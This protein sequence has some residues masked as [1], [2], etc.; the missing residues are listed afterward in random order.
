M[1]MNCGRAGIEIKVSEQV[2][3]QIDQICAI[4]RI[5]WQQYG[6]AKGKD[7]PWLFVDFCAA[8][9]FYAPVA[10]RFNTYVVPVGPVSNAYIDTMLAFEPIRE[11]M[12]AARNEV[13]VIQ[14][15]EVQSL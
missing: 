3:R 12:E 8:D 2:E 9:A 14:S 6:E 5:C 4:W 13:E 11:W 7:G 15:D 1:P 10:L